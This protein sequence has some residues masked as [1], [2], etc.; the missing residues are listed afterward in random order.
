MQLRLVRNPKGCTGEMSEMSCPFRTDETQRD[1]P[2]LTM[3]AVESVAILQGRRE[4]LIRHGAELYRLR[5]TASNK[6]ILTK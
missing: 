5:L 2:E 3:P 4:V 6:L 1:R